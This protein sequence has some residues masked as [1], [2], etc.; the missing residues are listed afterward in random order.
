MD[1]QIIG[2]IQKKNEQEKGKINI[3]TEPFY[4][5][6][7]K[8]LV[9]DDN[10]MNLKVFL[11]LLKSHG[12]QIDTAICG[13][14]GLSLMEQKSY[15]IV[16]MD[17]LMPEMDGV[18]TL[19]RAKELENNLSKDAVMIALTANAVSG[20]REMFLEEGFQDYLAKPIIAIQL[21]KMILNYL[22]E[23]LIQNAD[24]EQPVFSVSVS[25]ENAP[26]AEAENDIVDWERGRM[27][28]AGNEDFYTEILRT[29][30]D[31]HSDTTL[32]QCYEA[33]DFENYRIKV[34]AVK[35]NL[36]NIGAVD[37]S[38]MAKKLELALKN[39][40]DVNYVKAHHEEFICVYKKVVSKVE[41]YVYG[42]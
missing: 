14:D 15:H 39:E 13:K 4:A 32:S 28:C 36:A 21:E 7:A 37:A 8:I 20:A 11:G 2:D 40:K 18:E 42:E 9:V 1:E 23:A 34:H 26:V 16:F 5:P 41:K 17:H 27:F 12:M 10:E 38:E 31:A 33:S 24:S 35:T 6:E 29:F 19:K 3:S 25:H 30:L 22:P